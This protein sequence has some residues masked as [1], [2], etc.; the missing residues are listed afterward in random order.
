M[1]DWEFSS[2]R[3]Y[4]GFIDSLFIKTSLACELIG[5]SKE[6]FY[7]DS[8]KVIDKDKIKNIF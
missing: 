8:Y 5:V 1:E 7:E 4:C 2:F 6:T 3:E